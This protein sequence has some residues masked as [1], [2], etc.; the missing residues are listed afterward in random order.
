MDDHER[1]AIDDDWRDTVIE[2]ER[3]AHA[4]GYEKGVREA[5]NV[6]AAYS[7]ERVADGESYGAEDCYARILAL[8][9]APRGEGE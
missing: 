2:A 1:Y 4:A 9:T 7:A 8:L 5:A 3:K 6:C